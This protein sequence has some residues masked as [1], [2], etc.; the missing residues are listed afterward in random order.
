M[1]VN[2]SG[3]DANAQR[4]DFGGCLVISRGLSI[5]HKTPEGPRTHNI[6]IIITTTQ[7]DP[8]ERIYSRVPIYTF[9]Q[10]VDR[11]NKFSADRL[12]EGQILSK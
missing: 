10:M 7:E 6:K 4:Q 8:E 2:M 5:N 3:N 1:A 12:E 11:G 9:V